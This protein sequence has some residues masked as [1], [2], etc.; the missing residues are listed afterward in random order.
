MCNGVVGGRNKQR[1]A[2]DGRIN[3]CSSTPNGSNSGVHIIYCIM[4]HDCD[5]SRPSM[6]LL[7]YH[8]SPMEDTDEDESVDLKSRS[9]DKRLAAVG[10]QVPAKLRPPGRHLSPMLLPWIQTRMQMK[11][12]QMKPLCHLSLMDESN[13][14]ECIPLTS[15]VPLAEGKSKRIGVVTCGTT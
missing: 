11:P 6:K 14:C 4:V 10:A 15:E 12:S 3:T 5:I 2:Q 7:L 13:E 1:H 9:D 8:L